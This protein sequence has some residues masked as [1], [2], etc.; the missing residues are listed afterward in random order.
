MRKLFISL[1]F[2]A[3]CSLLAAQTTNPIQEAMA[4]Y[5]YETAL[6]LI[7][8]RNPD[9]PPT[10][11]KRESAER[12]GNNLE[13]LSVFQEVVARDSLNPRAYIEAAECCKSLAKYSEALD[14]TKMR[15]T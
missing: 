10:L 5:D 15:S 1:C 11:P 9:R 6:M 3:C 14:T 7:D 13:A 4:N 2:S 12:L 8:P